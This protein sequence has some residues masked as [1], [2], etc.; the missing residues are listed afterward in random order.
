MEKAKTDGKDE[1]RTGFRLLKLSGEP[2][3]TAPLPC[4]PVEGCPIPGA[5]PSPEA[6]AVA[7]GCVAVV[8][9]P[10][11]GVVMFDLQSPGCEKVVKRIP[12]LLPGNR[13]FMKKHVTYEGKR[14]EDSETA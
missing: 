5:S 11:K 9:E 4:G 1:Q 2:T 14:L 10:K 3:E 8:T 13:S 12:S 6:K 7:K